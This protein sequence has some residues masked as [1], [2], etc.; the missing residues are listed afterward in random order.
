MAS[1][2]TEAI[3]WHSSEEPRCDVCGLE[4][5]AGVAHRALTSDESMQVFRATSASDAGCVIAVNMRGRPLR[6]PLVGIGR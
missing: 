4:V 1:G 3:S 5:P 6:S 2:D